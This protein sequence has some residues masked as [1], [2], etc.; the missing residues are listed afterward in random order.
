MKHYD[1]K[2]NSGVVTAYESFNVE[3]LSPVIGA[4]ITGIDLSQPISDKAKEE[5]C[6]AYAKH[7]LLSFPEQDLSPDDQVT[8][9]Q[10]FGQTE[11]PRFFGEVMR[12]ILE[13]R[14]S[15]SRD[16]NRR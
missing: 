1:P 11:P 7:S 12:E 13:D 10:V 14:A 15:R 5:L 8:V 3:L 4:R 9:A 6:E 2:S 16:C